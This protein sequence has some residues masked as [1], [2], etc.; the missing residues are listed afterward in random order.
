ME[1]SVTVSIAADTSGILS[2]I[3][4]V[5]FVFVSASAGSVQDSKGSRSTS[6]NVRER[7]TSSFLV[8]MIHLL[9]LVTPKG[10]LTGIFLADP[11]KSGLYQILADGCV[12][13]AAADHPRTPM[14][15]GSILFKESRSST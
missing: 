12:P 14:I 2:P 10:I 8:Y 13:V 6:S 4:L 1:A 3:F 9:L 11:G 5:N 7:G 15:S